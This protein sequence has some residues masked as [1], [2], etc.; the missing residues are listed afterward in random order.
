VHQQ[1]QPRLAG[2]DGKG[3]KKGGQG[4]MVKQQVDATRST[5]SVKLCTRAGRQAGRQAGNKAR[6]CKGTQAWM[7][8]SPQVGLGEMRCAC[9]MVCVNGV[10]PR[11]PYPAS[12]GE[13]GPLA[14]REPRAQYGQAAGRA[15]GARLVWPLNGGAL[16]WWEQQATNEKGLMAWRCAV[17]QRA[18]SAVM[19]ARCRRVLGAVTC[20]CCACYALG[21]RQVRLLCSR[22]GRI[23]A[24]RRPSPLPLLSES[25]GIS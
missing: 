22:G 17:A 18:L 20:A 5:C 10:R 4:S 14:G 15:G 11:L 2:Q 6:Q 16:S 3:R 25:A 13:G 1:Q 8:R 19:S 9:V 7:R 21:T 23:Q 24:M 12:G